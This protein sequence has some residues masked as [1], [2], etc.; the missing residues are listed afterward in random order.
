MPL[1]RHRH[2]ERQRQCIGHDYGIYWER[3]SKMKS[4]SWDRKPEELQ[5]PK[6]DI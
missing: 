5:N 2:G 6:N 3:V 4:M 1:Q